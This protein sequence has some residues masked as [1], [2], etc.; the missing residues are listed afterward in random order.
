ME[1]A[2]ARHLQYWIFPYGGNSS[3]PLLKP[4]FQQSWYPRDSGTAHG[5]LAM[6]VMCDFEDRDKHLVSLVQLAIDA[7]AVA[8]GSS[9]LGAP[10]AGGAGF[11]ASPL[12]PIRLAGLLFDDDGMK[13]ARDIPS[14]NTDFYGNPVTKWGEINRV[15]YSMDAHAQYR[16]PPGYSQ[17]LGKPLYGDAPNADVTH[18][19]SSNGTVRDPNG[20]YDA[21]A[22]KWG[23]PT[24]AYPNILDDTYE[25]ML[26]DGEECQNLGTYMHMNSAMM[27]SMLSSIAMDDEGFWGGAVLDFALRRRQRSADVG[28]LGHRIRLSATRM[29]NTFHRDIGGHGGSGNGWMAQMWDLVLVGGRP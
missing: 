25:M 2:A 7:Y 8:E 14:G 12:W 10:F 9:G 17:P 6:Y 16:M 22:Y 26:I 29:A 27:G 11:F 18:G 5:Q 19:Q 15:Y 4:V 24:P 20:I 1:I 3:V 23:L 21:H 28:R 13:N